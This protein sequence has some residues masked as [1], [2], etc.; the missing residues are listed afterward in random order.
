MASLSLLLGNTAQAQNYPEKPVR[1][2]MPFAPGGLTDNVVRVMSAKLAE[3]LG[4]QVII[5]SRPGA[6]GNIGTQVVAQ[7]A[8][9]GYTLLAGFQGTLVINPFIY[10]K[11]PFDSVADF[12]PITIL[13]DGTL[14]LVAHPSVAANNIREL[15]ALAKS[16]PGSLSF[17]STGTGS[18]SHLTGELLKQRAGIDMV[19][20]PYKGGGQA[21]G[22]AIGGQ[23]PLLFTS[24]STVA[25][26]IK[27]GKLRALGVS[28]A[29]R[30]DALPDVPTFIENG[31]PDFVASSWIGLL[32]PAKTPPS[33]I[34]R[35]HR[36]AVAALQTPEVRE[37]YALLGI[38]P[39]GNTPEQY[40]DRIRTDMAR[41]EKVVRQAKIRLE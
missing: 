32:A 37:R 17:A 25:Q 35:L 4:Q 21:V 24:V 39:V 28:A 15:I 10:P 20:V 30:S 8:P 29:R 22:D 23:V 1:I 31:L 19:H 13:G 38:D 7:S 5:D 16:K 14:I 34:A 12:A 6:N 33:I 11:L 3:R 40:R 9:D 2:V 41:W 27:A 18:T 36:D 26:H